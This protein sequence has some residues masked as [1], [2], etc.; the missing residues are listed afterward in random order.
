M[1]FTNILKNIIVEATK[2]ETLMDALTK[3]T[4]D[5]EGKKKKPLLSKE[6]YNE[7]VKADP[8]TRL[9]DVDLDTEDKNELAKVKAGNYVQW[10]VKQ[11]LN[12]PTEIEK[13]EPGYEREFKQNQSVFMEDLYKVTN[14]LKKF[15]RFKNRLPQESR[16][17][18]K[19]NVQELYELV[20]EFS[21]EK[22]KATKE[23]KK[24]AAE[25]YE[26]PGADIVF[27]GNKWTVARIS[28]KGKLGKD[29]ACFYGGN[30]LEPSKGETR[31]C[32]SSPGLNW[33]D[34]Y[35]KDG[36]LYVVIPNKWE[37]KRGETSGLPA[38]RYQFHFQSNQ[39]M[40]VHDHSVNLVELLNGPMSEIKD[41]FKP[42]FAKNLVVGGDVL[43]IDSFSSGP[44]GKYIA[45]YG[46]DDVF[47]YLPDTLKD[48][49]IINKENNGIIIRIPED[50]KRFKQLEFLLLE[51]CVESIPD[52][53][54]EIKSLRFLSL[55]NN[56]KMTTIPACIAGLPNLTFIN[57]KG[58]DNIV[59]PDEIKRIATQVGKG[60]WDLEGDD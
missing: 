28:D 42:E 60:M 34:R 32:T 37:G 46:F 19:L 43:A 41:Y 49:Q 48:F 10:L 1:K 36:P 53:I 50:I 58:S 11:Y 9:N 26:H 15:D 47:K 22:T 30:Y 38:D 17:I 5:K 45:L 56:T 51:N 59:V 31:W 6:E 13:G 4:K 21:L 16:D 14:D 12:V 25:T 39:F 57:L 23:E 44:V 40:D 18:N 24:V 35:I 7:I 54:C 2:Y 55:H 29:A 3:P 27:R 8:T 52:S 33:F 20:K